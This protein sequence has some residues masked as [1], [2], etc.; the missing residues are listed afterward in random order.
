[1]VKKSIGRMITKI[2]DQMKNA[3][4]QKLILYSTHDT[5]L[6]PLLDLLGIF[7]DH[8][9]PFASSIIFELYQNVSGEKY[10]R[11]LYMMEEQKILGCSC[12]MCPFED[13]YSIMSPFAVTKHEF[14]GHTEL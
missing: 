8:W 10:V 7:N 9:P 1:M 2:L 14:S 3:T 13:F 11:V 12:V 5:A 6:I 4:N